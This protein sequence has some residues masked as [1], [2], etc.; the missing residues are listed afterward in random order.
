VDGRPVGGALQP[1]GAGPV[2]RVVAKHPEHKAIAIGHAMRKPLHLAFALWKS[3]K[4]FDRQHYP[5]EKPRPGPGGEPATREEPPEQEG[6]TRS[7]TA[8][9]K[10]EAKPAEEVVTAACP[11][12][13]PPEGP[14]GARAFTDFA[15]LKRQ[16]PMA[17][18]LEHLGLSSRL[19]G[20]GPQRRCACP[21]HRA[22]GRGRTFSVNLDD[23]VFHCFDARCGKQGDVIDL[24]A[25]LHHMNVRAAAVDLVR[26]FGLEPAPANATEKRHG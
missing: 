15:H 8:G 4:P 19:R 5:W 21:M 14:L 3:D 13:V 6:A 10:P 9:H 2:G 1:G 23:N 20:S 17:R 12:T 7:Q 25:E 26:T 24:W 16:L 11:S 18:V 22:D